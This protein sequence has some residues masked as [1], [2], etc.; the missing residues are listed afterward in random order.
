LRPAYS[1]HDA[2]I[3]ADALRSIGFTLVGD[4]AQL[5]VDKV[6]LDDLIQKFSRQI[7]NANL[8]LFFYAGHAFQIKGKNF[9]V[10]ISANPVREAEVYLQT[11]DVTLVLRQLEKAAK[12]NLMVLDACREN[13][14]PPY[15]MGQSGKRKGLAPMGAL[16][17]TMVAFA[18]QPDTIA[19]E[20]DGKSVYSQTLAKTIRV[21]GLNVF[22]MFNDVGLAVMQAT[23]G[24]QK[25]WLS[26]LATNNLGNIVLLPS[27]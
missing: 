23:K 7:V 24:V 5:N 16:D 4:G 18:A 20:L 11:V 15:V 17:D 8:A 26:A 25:P 21:R 10:P 9:I 27:P 2:Q 14:F 13:P 6:T 1:V 12:Y 19:L 3:I 22:S